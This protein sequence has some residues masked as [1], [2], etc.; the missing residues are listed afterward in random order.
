MA[1][2]IENSSLKE[3]T[4]LALDVQ[5][6]RLIEIESIEDLKQYFTENKNPNFYV[7][8]GGSN[9]LFLHDFDGDILKIDLKGISVEKETK[10]HIWLKAAAGENWHEFILNCL[11]KNWGGLENLSLIPG[12]VGASPIQNIGAYGVEVKNHIEHVEAFDI[13]NL[14]LKTFSNAECQFGYRESIFKRALKGKF[15]V[16]AVTFKLTKKDH[17]LRISYGAIQQELASKN[18]ENPTIQEISD[19]VISIRSSKLPDP[20]ICPNTG[21]FFKNPIV[22][23]E[24]YLKLEQKYPEIPHYRVDD[25]HVK[26]P[27]GWLIEKAGWKGKR[28]GK[29]GVH[30]MQALVLI[31]PDFGTGKE[32]Y[33]FSTEIIQSIQNQFGIE[34][35]REVNIID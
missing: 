34:L 8:G 20:K 1:K 12:T 13:E 26:I 5:A 22:P 32:V 4:T 35:E 19:A 28:M 16:T 11:A 23:K 29:V 15:I 31:N 17:E 14:T 33:D 27:A 24:T 3:F 30:H 2:I 10:N 25:T 7:L 6:K 21:S 18:I 9:V